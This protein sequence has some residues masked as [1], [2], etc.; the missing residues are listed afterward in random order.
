MDYA[1]LANGVTENQCLHPFPHAVV[2][3][4]L[5]PNVAQA[6]SN[7]LP[8]PDAPVWASVEHSHQVGKLACEDVTKLPPVIQTIAHSLLRPELAVSLRQFNRGERVYPDPYFSNG[9]LHAMCPSGHLSPHC[10]PDFHTLTGLR[11]A[12][13]LVLFLTTAGPDDGGELVLYSAG[14]PSKVI[15]S[16]AGRCVIFSNNAKSIHGVLKWRGAGLRYTF[17]AFF[18][19]ADEIHQKL[20]YSP[21]WK[22]AADETCRRRPLLRMASQAAFLISRQLAAAHQKMK[23]LGYSLA[24]RA[25]SAEGDKETGS[26]QNP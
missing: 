2:D 25:T 1:R 15:K 24:E 3:G 9:G 10:D 22:P 21:R 14:K 7:E 23:Q 11:R 13:T 26:R 17:G 6:I 20:I 12:V 5:D 8:S 16:V 19:A 4:L 18:Y